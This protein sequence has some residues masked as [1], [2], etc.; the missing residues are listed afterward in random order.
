MIH[1]QALGELCEA[2]WKNARLVLKGEGARQLVE[3]GILPADCS[4]AKADDLFTVKFFV[5]RRCVSGPRAKWN[6]Q[7]GI[8]TAIKF[9]EELYKRCPGIQAECGPLKPRSISTPAPT[10]LVEVKLTLDFPKQTSIYQGN[11][12]AASRAID[13]NKNTAWG[14]GSCTHTAQENGRILGWWTANLIG[15]KSQQEFD[16]WF[17]AE[18]NQLRGSGKPMGYPED[19]VTVTN[20]RLDQLCQ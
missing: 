14:G 11:N 7:Q 20:R 16:A 15:K 8:C 10:P 4:N 3:A 13:G 19:L 6:Q 2:I 12:G 18:N 1:L 9:D 5:D 17:R